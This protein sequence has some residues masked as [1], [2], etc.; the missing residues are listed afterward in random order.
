MRVDLHVHSTAS[1]GSLS[2]GAVVSAAGAGGLDIIALTDHDTAA[3]YPEARDA[4]IGI[5]HVIPGIEISS[6]HGD[7]ELHILGYYIDPG[8]PAMTGHGHDARQRRND[9]MS[10]M[11]E[12]LR[13]QGVEMELAEV[14]AAAGPAE[15]LARPHLARV[16]IQRGYAQ[17]VSHAF[18]RWI[19]DACPAYRPVN[20]LNPA[21][22][23]DR[24]HEAGGIAVWAHPPM[25]TFRSEI[26]R[27]RAQG[28]DGVEVFRPRCPAS[29]SLELEREANALG[30]LVT[31]GSDWHGDWNGRLGSFALG[32]EEVGAMLERGGI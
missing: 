3:G 1:D 28:L 8:H 12:A 14:V 5:I 6:S 20:L 17:N 32:R 2:P 25:D 30:L 16:L 24:I 23:I 31:G 15:G 29:D 22:A 19:G 4:A 7:G 13:G 21:Q 9:R 11:L 10:E 27:F 18:E 26:R